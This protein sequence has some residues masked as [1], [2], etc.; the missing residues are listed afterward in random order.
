MY[1]NNADSS[2]CF[3]NRLNGGV[4][5]E[6]QQPGEHEPTSAL[7]NYCKRKVRIPVSFQISILSRNS[8]KH[9]LLINDA[10]AYV[11]F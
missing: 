1:R 10:E 4:H 5:D 7:L 11:M 2:F 3:I 8:K 6:L 9:N